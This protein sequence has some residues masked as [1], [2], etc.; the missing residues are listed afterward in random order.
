MRRRK[1]FLLGVGCQKGGTTW[2]HDYLHSLPE[3]DFGFAK[4][5]HTFDARWVDAYKPLQLE[6]VR[7][8][9][10]VV[11]K[12]QRWRWVPTPKLS[13]RLASLARLVAFCDAPALYVNHFD[14]LW[15]QDER[16]QIVGDITPEYSALRPEHF[17]AIRELVEGKGF[18]IK[19]MLLMRDPVERCFAAVRSAWQFKTRDGRRPDLDLI[20]LLKE[21]YASPGFEV[22][23][24][25]DRII[26]TLESEFRPEEIY[27]GFYETMFNRTAIEQILG[28]L[29]L[30][31]S[32]LPDFERRLNE[33]IRPMEIPDALAREIRD[34]YRDTYAFCAERFGR[35]FIAGIWSRP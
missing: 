21:Q 9:D 8:L 17:R 29:G 35:D 19:V 4:E 27:Y 5:Y 14:R 20:E 26:A 11:R 18:E 31:L 23:T 10:K 7:K 12:K 3:C 33:S 16:V 24:R 15:H 13:R 32:R 34:F 30:T 1:V 22:R 2:L 28:F 25:Y 6:R